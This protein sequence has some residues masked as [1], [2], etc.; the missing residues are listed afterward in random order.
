MKGENREKQ[1]PFL[2]IIHGELHEKQSFYNVLENRYHT[3]CI[4][5]LCNKR[6]LGSSYGWLVLVDRFTYD[7]CLWNP[8]SSSIIELPILDRAHLYNRCVLSKPPTEPDC[9]ILFNSSSTLEQS[10]CKIG[11]DEFGHHSLKQEKYDLKAIASFQNKIYGIIEDDECDYKVVTI[12][13]VGNS[14]LEL[15]R[16]FVDDEGQPWIGPQPSP[17]WVTWKQSCLIESPCGGELL[18]VTKMYSGNYLNRFRVFRVD[19]DGNEIMELE[20]IG[21]Q[22]IFIS[23]W[24]TG[25]CCSSSGRIKS[26]SIYYTDEEISRDIY[27]YSLDDGHKTSFT[28]SP[29]VGRYVPLTYWVEH[30]VLDQLINNTFE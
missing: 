24:G 2:L 22:T 15:K 13:L 29:V 8:I 25:F 16:M 30:G 19:T 18:L 9:H 11:D 14:S 17:N 28:P 6:V 1:P 5:I 23:H 27:I 4:P 21:K 3:T 7:C 12:N 10:F 26:N 20:D